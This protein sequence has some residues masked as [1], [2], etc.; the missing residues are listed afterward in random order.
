MSKPHIIAFFAD[1]M[2]TTYYST[3][4]QLLKEKLTAWNFPFTIEDYNVKR[5]ARPL[6]ITNTRKKPG[7]ILD[8]L[9]RL[10]SDVLYVDVDTNVVKP[11]DTR[12]FISS[13]DFAAPKFTGASL[14]SPSLLI[15]STVMWFRYCE[16]TLT[17]V[18]DWKA[19]CEDHKG[20][21]GDHRILSNLLHEVSRDD[22]NWGFLPDRYA[23][24]REQ[25]DSV[26]TMGLAKGVESRDI[27]MRKVRTQI[28]EG[29]IT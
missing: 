17:L 22:I 20:L 29:N 12:D 13:Y 1:P 6:W 3:H 5:G 8:T 11:P 9:Q 28:K 14:V 4:A 10:R 7:F 23:H 24:H 21:H 18:S 16:A 15:R 25:P 26:M 2:G 19:R 27:H